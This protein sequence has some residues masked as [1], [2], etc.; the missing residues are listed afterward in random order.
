MKGLTVYSNL[1]AHLTVPGVTTA[2]GVAPSVPG[3]AGCCGPGGGGPGWTGGPT[4]GWDMIGSGFA[5][6]GGGIC[7]G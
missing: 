5:P 1:F 2:P 3:A 6:R 4:G 7:P